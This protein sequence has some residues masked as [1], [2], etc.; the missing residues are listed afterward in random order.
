MAVTVPVKQYDPIPGAG[1]RRI[2]FLQ[3]LR[4]QKHHPALH[5]RQNILELLFIICIADVHITKYRFI[6]HQL[7]LTLHTFD[8]GRME[9]T[10]VNDHTV[11]PKDHEP[12]LRNLLLHPISQLLCRL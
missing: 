4:P 1:I 5:I 3:H 12:Y 8:H 9:G 2:I 6:T 10:L 7:R 11:L